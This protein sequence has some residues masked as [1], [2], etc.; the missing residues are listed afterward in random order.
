MKKSWLIT[1]LINFCIA[2]SM[3]VILRYVYVNP[4][5]INY[6]YLIHGHSHTAMLGWIYL[7]LYS[8]IFHYF[9]PKNQSLEKKYNQLFWITQ[10][11]IIGM[12]FSFPFQ[13]YALVSIFFSTL[14]IFCSYYFCYRVWKDHETD[15]S[16]E[17]KVLLTALLFM[18]FSTIGVWCL[19]PVATTGGKGS[20]FYQVA[21]QFFI[22]FQ[23]NGWFTFGVIAIFLNQFQKI[24]CDLNTSVFNWFFYSLITAT[25][26]NFALPISW[27]ISIPTLQW[28]NQ[29][30]LLAQLISSIA[31]ILLIRP[32]YKKLIEQ[33]AFI[34][35]LLY[36]FALISFILKTGIQ[37][38]TFFPK[39]AILSHTIR[40][41]V[42]GFIHLSMLG[43]I[44]GFLFAFITGISLFN[45][46]NK[47]S[48]A[49]LNLFMICFVIT[50][51]LLFTQ[52]AFFY[53]GK[54]ML[55]YYYI[56]LLIASIGLPAG[57]LLFVIPFF[58]SKKSIL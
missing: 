57:T 40:N 25:F 8:F 16:S 22:H 19:G 11:S 38:V 4:L 36:C 10:L 9:I 43:L 31:F 7:M 2:A 42:I 29:L 20:A 51:I 34:T 14:H 3:G 30:G 28:I 37:F 35:K 27:Y 18:M 56:I 13:G 58:K 23:F 47:I 44:T 15:T 5:N 6:A 41:F 50:E 52:G 26:L 45:S 21:I 39:I 53:L 49:G 17:K 54:G 55:P 32:H 33:S 46:E 12:I 1:C 48:K 24:K